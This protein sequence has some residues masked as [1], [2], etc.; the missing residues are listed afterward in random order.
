[1]MVV[2]FNNNLFVNLFSYSFL[3]FYYSIDQCLLQTTVLIII[4]HEI[5]LKLVPLDPRIETDSKTPR[6]PHSQVPLHLL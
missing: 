3:L 6:F 1:M 2:L 5:K 4:L